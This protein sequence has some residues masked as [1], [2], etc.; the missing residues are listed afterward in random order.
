MGREEKKRDSKTMT[1]KRKKVSDR[2]KTRTRNCPN[3]A[4]GLN[5]YTEKQWPLG[6]VF[7]SN[8]LYPAYK[9]R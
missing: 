3:N 9:G 2:C 5:S 6:I 8:W 1:E 7:L 4:N